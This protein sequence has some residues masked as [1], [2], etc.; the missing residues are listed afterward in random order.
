MFRCRFKAALSQ[1]NWSRFNEVQLLQSRL[2]TASDRSRSQAEPVR[3]ASYNSSKFC[4][5]IELC[6]LTLGLDK[7]CN[8]LKE[9]GGNIGLDFR[10]RG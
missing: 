7:H 8:C 5:L 10:A 6:L 4:K 2:Q 3:T 9:V 1:F